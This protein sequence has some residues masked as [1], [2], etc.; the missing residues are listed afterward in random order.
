MNRVE[1]N[2]ISSFRKVKLDVMKIQNTLL[3]L[4]EAQIKMLSLL[5]LERLKEKS[6]SYIPLKSRKKSYISSKNGGKFHILE[7]PF[8]KNI[9]NKNRVSFGSKTVALKKGYNPCKCIK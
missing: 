8:A 2:V 1:K 6:V 3:E 9:S 7:C 5:E 4:K